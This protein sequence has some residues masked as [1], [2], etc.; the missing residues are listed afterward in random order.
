M[1][2][3]VVTYKNIEE[4]KESKEVRKK[5]KKVQHLNHQAL[6]VIVLCSQSDLKEPGNSRNCGLL[7]LFLPHG[8]FL[9]LTLTPSWLC[10]PFTCITAFDKPYK[11]SLLILLFKEY[12]ARIRKL[13][14]LLTP[15]LLCIEYF[16]EH[17]THSQES[18]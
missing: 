14:S 2:I 15:S 3:M 6:G 12:L 17:L 18:P 8:F 7:I 9:L 16:L 10:L 11:S 5:W 4:N 1:A 13:A